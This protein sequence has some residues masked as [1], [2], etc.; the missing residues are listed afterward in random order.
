M[1]RREYEM[2]FL[3]SRLIEIHVCPKPNI[4]KFDHIYRKYDNIS[5]V[6]YIWY[7]HILYDESDVIKLVF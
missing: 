5:N 3:H 1:N 7:E 2:Y 6:K 4:Y